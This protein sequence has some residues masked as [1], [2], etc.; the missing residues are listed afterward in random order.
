MHKGRVVSVHRNVS[1][2]KLFDGFQLKLLYR[3]DYIKRCQANLL[4]F[5]YY[6]KPIKSL[7]TPLKKN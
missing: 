5:H 2:P 1:L 6:E 7:E 3:G 4:L